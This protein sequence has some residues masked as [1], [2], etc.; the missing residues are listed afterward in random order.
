MVALDQSRSEKNRAVRLLESQVSGGGETHVDLREQE[1]QQGFGTRVLMPIMAALGRIAR[2]IT[3][4][5]SRDRIAKK[6]QL[7]GTIEGWDAERVMAFKVIGA[8][9]GMG[10]GLVDLRR[11]SIPRRSSRSSSSRC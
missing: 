6:L 9:V 1:M 5:D 11:C 3:P 4:L 2:R 7:A 10:A 8:V